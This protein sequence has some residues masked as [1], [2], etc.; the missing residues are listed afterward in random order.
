MGG[1]AGE[2]PAFVLLVFISLSWEMKTAS[3]VM[4]RPFRWSLTFW[5]DFC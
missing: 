5:V 4:D 3:F 2:G 1:G